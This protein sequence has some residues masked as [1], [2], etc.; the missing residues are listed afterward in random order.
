MTQQAAARNPFMLMIS[1]EIVLAAVEK[2]ERLSQLSR[3]LCRPLDR[4]GP[5]GTGAL[6]SG[7]SDA[8][9]DVDGTPAISADE[10]DARS[11]EN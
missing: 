8:E 9:A 2:S 7:G 6:A 1:P 10:T 4:V 5:P 11:G 3:H